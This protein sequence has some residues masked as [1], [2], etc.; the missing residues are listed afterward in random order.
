VF[1]PPA[2]LAPTCNDN[3]KL[4]IFQAASRTSVFKDRPY[5]FGTLTPSKNLAI[6]GDGWLKTTVE[7]L[8]AAGVKTIASIY[9]DT[10]VWPGMCG[11]PKED[12]S[13]SSIASLAEQLGL[14]ILGMDAVP[15]VVDVAAST[16]AM[17]PIAEKVRQVNASQ[18][19]T[20]REQTAHDTRANDA[21]H[22]YKRRRPVF[23]PPP[24]CSHLRVGVPRTPL[25]A[26]SGAPRSQMAPTGAPRSQTALSGEIRKQLARFGSNRS[27]Q[28]LYGALARPFVRTCV[29]HTCAELE[30]VLYE[31]S[32]IKA[33]GGG[34]VSV[35]EPMRE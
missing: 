22:A 5:A 30:T 34:E 2:L 31:L 12:G 20:T 4:A 24:L 3:K 26:L 18:R 11:T 8:A 1:V 10:S 6:P 14:T 16:T 28:A 13:P 33:K 19:R 23:S 9:E 35:S 21:R 17:L 7:A 15:K 27:Q 25:T 29:W 32:L